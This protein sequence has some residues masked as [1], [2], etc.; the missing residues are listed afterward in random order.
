MGSRTHAD[1]EIFAGELQRTGFVPVPARSTAAAYS[2]RWR[3]R[4]PLGVSDTLVGEEGDVAIDRLG[5]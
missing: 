4:T 1:L 5:A 2:D 3:R